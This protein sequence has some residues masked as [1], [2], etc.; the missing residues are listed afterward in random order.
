MKEMQIDTV[1]IYAKQEAPELV[2]A[3][4]IVKDMLPEADKKD[5]N[6]MIKLLVGW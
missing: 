4:L 6:A 5:L 3:A 1:D 2:R